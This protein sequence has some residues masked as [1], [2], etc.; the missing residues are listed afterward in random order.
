LLL[1]HRAEPAE[2]RRCHNAGFNKIF[3]GTIME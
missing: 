2:L 3:S 1:V